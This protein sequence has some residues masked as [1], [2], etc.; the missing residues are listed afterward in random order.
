MFKNGDDCCRLSATLA[1]LENELLIAAVGMPAIK[2]ITGT[3]KCVIKN[4]SLKREVRHHVSCVQ[5]TTL[6][7][8]CGG[9]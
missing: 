8:S 6:E 3:C 1:G 5:D 2:N 7:Q 4:V 9:R